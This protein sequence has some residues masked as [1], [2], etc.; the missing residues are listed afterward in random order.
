M[1]AN[2]SRSTF[3]EFWPWSIEETV[4]IWSIR[5][6]FQTRLVHKLIREKDYGSDDVYAFLGVTCATGILNPD[7][8]KI[9]REMIEKLLQTERNFG[10]TKCSEYIVVNIELLK[11]E[12]FITNREAEVLM[13]FILETHIEEFSKILAC[14]G[15][16]TTE[17]MLKILVFALGGSA[18]ELHICFNSDSMLAVTGLMTLDQE[19]ACP[20][21]EKVKLLPGLADW[22]MSPQNSVMNLL[23]DA[24]ISNHAQKP[25]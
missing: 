11:K 7:P 15:P 17:R 18:E 19:A 16:M 6:I 23:A 21:N 12:L 2:S 5:I 13:F 4:R 9:N 25:M 20:L 22:M 24:S 8:L 14:L 1:D 3:D 10:R